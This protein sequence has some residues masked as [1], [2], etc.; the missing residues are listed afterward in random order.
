MQAPTEQTRKK[1]ALYS[2]SGN[3]HRAVLRFAGHAT[4]NF[5]FVE[6]EEDGAPA[7]AGRT[8]GARPHEPTARRSAQPAPHCE[9]KHPPA[10]SPHGLLVDHPKPLRR[11]LRLAATVQPERPPTRGRGIF[12]SRIR[13]LMLAGRR[14]ADAFPRMPHP[15]L[16]AHVAAGRSRGRELAGPRSKPIRTR[17]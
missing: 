7:L 10:V 11:T 6:G 9:H 8:K 16:E 12:V 3:W 13:I 2:C 5:H 4:N 14:V 1:I 15:H 17:L